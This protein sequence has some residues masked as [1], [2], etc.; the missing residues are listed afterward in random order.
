MKLNQIISLITIFSILV[1][2]L[3]FVV[4]Q[5]IEPPQ[6]V[7]TDIFGCAGQTFGRCLTG[8]ANW[9]FHLLIVVA[10]ALA[11]I[12]IIFAGITYIL[13]GAEAE[14]RQKAT[15]RLIY[16]AVGLVVAFLA[17]AITQILQRFLQQQTGTG[18]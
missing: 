14:G 7:P 2:Y 6:T 4:G 17:F 13:Q 1:P 18:I 3:S 12:F 9:V 8:I 10:L 15:N 5:D 11:V 16:A